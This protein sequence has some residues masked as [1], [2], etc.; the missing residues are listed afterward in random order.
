MGSNG[1][2]TFGAPFTSFTPEP[3]PIYNNGYGSDYSNSY[4]SG[5]PYPGYNSSSYYNISGSGY[6]PYGSSNDGWSQSNIPD[7]SLSGWS[8]SSLPSNLGGGWSDSSFP[9]D[10]PGGWSGSSSPGA[11]TGGWFDTSSSSSSADYSSMFYSS[12]P[13]YNGW[14][15]NSG[16]YGSNPWSS[17]SSGQYHPYSSYPEEEMCYYYYDA[18]GN[19]IFS[20]RDYQNYHSSSYSHSWHSSASGNCNFTEYLPLCQPYN[21][22]NYGQVEAIIAPFWHD[23]DPRINGGKLY[24][25]LENITS[26]SNVLSRAKDEIWVG[27]GEMFQPTNALIAT[28]E[29]VQQYSTCNGLVTYFI[30]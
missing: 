28:W 14:S 12:D 15:Y 6:N 26:A 20:H 13:S 4:S 10:L 3:F 23:I 1:Y 8:D 17:Y 21:N 5:G 30:N 7:D 19:M 22:Y 25:R 2:V 11:S 24:Y 27:T 29:N 9:S 16:P 18:E